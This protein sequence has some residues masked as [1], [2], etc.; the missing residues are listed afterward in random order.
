VENM[1]CKLNKRKGYKK[2]YLHHVNHILTHLSQQPSLLSVLNYQTQ[3][4]KIHHPHRII[5]HKEQ[6]L[7][8][9]QKE[10]SHKL[11]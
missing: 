9:N 2:V 7:T 8:Q 1:T 11:L 4:I 3:L 6:W 5:I 10:T